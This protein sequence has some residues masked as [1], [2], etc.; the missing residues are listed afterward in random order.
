[1][2]A[3][4]KTIAITTL[5]V[6]VAAGAAYLGLSQNAPAA[7]QPDIF[8]TKD[9]RQDRALWATPA[10]YRMNTAGQ[11]RGMA[12]DI[13][14][15]EDASGQPAAARPYGSEGTAKPGNLKLESPYPFTTAEAHYEAWLKEANGGTKHTKETLPDWGGKWEGG[16]GFGGGGSPP[17]D[18]VKLL[19]PMYQESYVQELKAGTEGR[20]WGAGSFCL[21]GGF[22]SAIGAEEFVVTPTK[23]YTL[24]SG[25]GNNTIRCIYTDGSGHTAKDLQ[26]PKWHGESVGFWNG[27]TLVVHT[28]Q[29]RGWKGG[30][31]EYTDKLETVEKYRRVGD[32]IEGE[33]T[34]YDPDVFVKP[35]HAKL[36]FNLAKDNRPE[37]RPLYNTCS[38]TNG[39]SPKVFMDDKGLLNEHIKGDPGFTWDTADTRPWSSWLD[40]SDRRYKAYLAAGGTPPG[41]DVAAEH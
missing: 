30:V 15:P 14:A 24:A 25:N 29:I 3:N 38:D 5:V 35:V 31:S 33:I 26:F 23:V 22:F 7:A 13:V 1:V 12:L 16:G 41:R 40:E 32:K 10:Y 8:T 11:L 17:S 18:T 37:T 6:A 9:F 4:S 21:P 34:L 27:D 2:R 39:P 36:N 20:I 19:K 28:N